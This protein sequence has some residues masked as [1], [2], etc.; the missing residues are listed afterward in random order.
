MADETRDVSGSEQMSVVVRYVM[1][2]MVGVNVVHERFL[3]FIRLEE[4]DAKSLA[5]KLANFLKSLGVNLSD[6]IAQCYDGLVRT[7]LHTYIN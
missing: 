4:F 7:F 6:C 1:D 3:G 2:D 5:E